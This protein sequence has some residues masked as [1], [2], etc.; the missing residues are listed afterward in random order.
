MYQGTLFSLHP[1]EGFIAHRAL[2]FSLV[3]RDAQPILKPGAHISKYGQVLWASS[4]ICANPFLYILC[5]L[6][7]GLAGRYHCYP[8]REKRGS[9]WREREREREARLRLEYPLRCRG[10]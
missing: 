10:Y 8:R 9:G 4:P 3:S 1:R 6:H 7:L 5:E 2:P